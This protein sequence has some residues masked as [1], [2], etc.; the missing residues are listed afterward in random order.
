MR[1]FRTF[2]GDKVIFPIEG[3]VGE[4]TL[5][6]VERSG[7]MLITDC[8]VEGKAAGDLVIPPPSWLRRVVDVG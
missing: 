3:S 2:I 4:G 8:K 7:Y 5:R 1:L 6:A